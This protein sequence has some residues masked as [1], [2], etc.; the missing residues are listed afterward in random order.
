[1][2]CDTVNISG[3]FFIKTMLEQEGGKSGSL[4]SASHKFVKPCFVFN[5]RSH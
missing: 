3:F 4:V 1:M 5:K 2:L